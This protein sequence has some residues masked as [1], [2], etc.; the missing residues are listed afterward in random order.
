MSVIW[1]GPACVQSPARARA[2]WAAPVGHAG[3]PPSMP[4]GCGAGR[5]R[6]WARPVCVAGVAFVFVRAVRQWAGARGWTDGMG[7]T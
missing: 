6:R 7:C 1:A 2:A 4:G 5:A 3:R